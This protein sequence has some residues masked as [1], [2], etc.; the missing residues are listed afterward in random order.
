MNKVAKFFS[1]IKTIW[2]G[3][4]LLGSVVVYAG[5]SRY[6]LKVDASK[7]VSEIAYKTDLSAMQRNAED[8]QIRKAYETDPQKIK[9]LEAQISIKKDRIHTLIKNHPSNQGRH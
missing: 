9:M 3:L 4:A 8:M 7:I 1:D 2:V 5:D 6:M